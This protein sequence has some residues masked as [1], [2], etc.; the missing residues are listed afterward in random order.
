MTTTL[1]CNFDGCG[2][3]VAPEKA[4]VPRIEAIR[5]AEGKSSITPSDLARHVFCEEHGAL[6]RGFTGGMFSYAETVKRLE[7]RAAE[8]VQ[9]KQFFAKYA[10][11]RKAAPGKPAPKPESGKNAMQIAFERAK[12]AAA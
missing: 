10:E 1:K 5:Q 8:R 6:G 4:L 9:A 11:P 12:T 7:Q 3:E 2:I